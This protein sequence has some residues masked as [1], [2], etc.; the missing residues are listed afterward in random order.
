MAETTTEKKTTAKKTTAKKS[1]P[2][3][4]EVAVETVQETVVAEEPV[5]EEK[6]AQDP[7]FQDSGDVMFGNPEDYMEPVNEAGPSNEFE[8]TPV[9]K[10][11][12]DA[13]QAL[14]AVKI[15]EEPVDEK[16]VEDAKEL[17]SS[18]DEFEEAKK[19]L[20]ERVAKLDEPDEAEAVIKD[21]IKNIEAI[22]AKTEKIAKRYS[23]YQISNSWNGQIQDW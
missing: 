17:S 23:N 4:E 8:E 21:Q 9:D 6:P 22:K 19:T 5:A 10:S 7:Q 11:E 16:V 20:D 15:E 1:A 13:E 18:I 12:P 14:E 3:A 2:K